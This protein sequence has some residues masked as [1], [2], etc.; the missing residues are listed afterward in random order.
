M[1][2]AAPLPA[3]VPPIP[4]ARRSFVG[5]P[6]TTAPSHVVHSPVTRTAASLHRLSKR[7]QEVLPLLCLRLSNQEIA[8]ILS[9]SPRTVQSHVASILATLG[10]ANRR[11]AAAIAVQL[12]TTSCRVP[13]GRA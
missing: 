9:L 1:S 12:D 13:A 5:Q 8:A 6:A 7:E 10:A 3:S 2:E 4:W 11:E